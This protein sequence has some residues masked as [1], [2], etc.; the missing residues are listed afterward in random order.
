MAW[1]AWIFRLTLPV[2]VTGLG[3]VIFDATYFV[4]FTSE[5]IG[6]ALIPA[7]RARRATPVRRDRGSRALILPTVGGS[8]IIALDFG[9]SGVGSLP[10]WVFY[11]GIFLML[12]GV[13]VR[14]WAI[15][16]LGRFFSLNVQVVEDHRVVD[17]G[18]YRLIR[19]PSYTGILITFIGIS[20]AVQS[21]GALLVLLAVFTVAFGYRIRVEEKTLLSELGDA[22]ASYMKRTRRIIPYLI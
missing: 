14:Q 17:T 4:W 20:L 9:Y 21:L 5:I 7:L 19:H 16:V 22:Y 6:A 15:A 2:F 1:S 12:L 3:L 13:V 18:P 8:L 11:P 10:D